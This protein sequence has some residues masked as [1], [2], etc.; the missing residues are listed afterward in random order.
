MFVL[1]RFRKY[2]FFCLVAINW[3]LTANNASAQTTHDKYQL[4]IRQATAAIKIDGVLDETDWLQADVANNFFS[5][6][7]YDTSFAKSKTECRVTYDK[8]NFY[9]SAVCF[10]E[11]PGNYVI[12]SLKRDYTYAVTDAFAIVLD[13]FLDGTN[14]FNFG[15]NPYNVPCE[16]S[17]DYGG[18]FGV[19][20]DWNVKWISE[21]KIEDGK[22]VCEM[23]IPFNSIRFKPHA[24][25]WYI[26]FIRNDLKR[27]E[28][29]GWV[30]VP[31]SFNA[32]SLAFTGTLIWDKPLEK[33]GANFSLIPYAIGSVNTIATEGNEIHATPNFGLD[34]KVAVSSSLN[35]DVTVNPDFSQ[36]EVDAQQTNL[37]RYNLFYP[38]KRSF[39]IENSD[40]FGQ[41]G[42]RQIRPFFSRNVGLNN[43]NVIPIQGGLRLSGKLT[44]N[45]RIGVLSIQ[46]ADDSIGG[47]AISG[48]NYSVL[49]YQRKLFSRSN[50]AFIGVNRQAFN[51]FEIQKKDFNRVGGIQYNLASAN[52]KL[53][54]FAFFMYSNNMVSSYRA[55]SHAAFWIYNTQKWTVV[56]NHEYVGKNFIADVGFVPRVNN[57]DA[58]TK[59]VIRN[60]Y[61]RLEP[62]IT[63]R[64]FP[65]GSLKSK[66][67]SFSVQLYSSDYLNEEYKPTELFNS[68]VFQTN[69]QN[70][71]RFGIDLATTHLNLQYGTSLNS[72]DTLYF[73]PGKYNYQD[74]A[75]RFNSN[76]RKVFNY[77]LN[78]QYGSF[79]TGEKFT[80]N[81]TITYRL[82]PYANLSL[83]VNYNQVDLPAPFQDFYL[84]LVGPKLEFTF[85]HNFFFS[86]F[87]QYNTQVENFNINGR[88][89][90][91]F[92]PLSYL[93]LVY[94]DNYDTV[95]FGNKN[96]AVVLK[97][98]YWL[99]I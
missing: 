90:W 69:F 17:I 35:L 44:P 82:Q 73:L 23:A 46:T 57:Y 92:K 5:I 62:A 47:A 76:L 72:K 20:T 28:Q 22:W 94:S 93:Y 91:Q 58:A 64:F 81:T 66:V 36:V 89:Q 42:F 4:N 41:F 56:Y 1:M 30:P 14:G 83:A 55:Y 33:T 54:G 78:A 10:D 52:N 2:I 63:R 53:V 71:A 49:A 48:Q 50:L 24:D 84:L 85:T 75:L 59:T 34:G 86:T 79:Y 26:N 40:L 51:H 6:L 25:K 68:V 99:S 29:S 11:L 37:T 27:N 39:F 98:V 38:E 67:N 61:W 16:G 12:Q 18:S 43:G 21:T 96:R 97:F 31:R 3:Q 87:L 8:N 32:S 65:A 19:S 45:N 15:V 13:P 74:V 70:S 9:V 60:S 95:N 88:L 80:F 77:T 7:P